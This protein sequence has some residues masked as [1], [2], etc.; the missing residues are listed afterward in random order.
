MPIH[1]NLQSENGDWKDIN[2]KVYQRGEGSCLV[3]N[4]DENTL[5]IH[6]RSEEGKI[7]LLETLSD[8]ILSHLERERKEVSKDDKT[9]EGS[10][11]GED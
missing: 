6:Y 8:K 1:L 4:L 5:C 11:K 10:S 7:K 3:L 9:E 2:L